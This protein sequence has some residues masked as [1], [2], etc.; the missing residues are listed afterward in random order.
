MKLDGLTKGERFIVGWQ[1]HLAGS[2][3]HSLAMAFIAADNI[4]LAKLRL[5]FPEEVDAFINYGN[6]PHWWGD[7]QRKIGVKQNGTFEA[8]SK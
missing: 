1:Y 2:F 8:E 3:M 4:N 7:L 5:A 6:T